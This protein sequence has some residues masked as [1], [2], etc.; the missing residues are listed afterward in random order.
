MYNR[1]GGEDLATYKTPTLTWNEVKALKGAVTQG[2]LP[3]G[4][5]N[6]F[7]AT[8]AER[9][10]PGSGFITEKDTDHAALGASGADGLTIAE[11]AGAPVP[12]SLPPDQIRDLQARLP[13]TAR[14]GSLPPATQKNS[15]PN[16][17]RR[18]DALFDADHVSDRASPSSAS[19]SS[20]L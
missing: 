17:Q 7:A 19:S 15:L 4:G 20:V 14:V 12:A 10:D 6:Q 18:I 2:L 13:S 11:L 3:D 8:E 9:V 1:E 5:V 16:L